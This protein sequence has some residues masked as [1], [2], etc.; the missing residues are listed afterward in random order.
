[1]PTEYVV[2]K[3]AA[4]YRNTRR[5]QKETEDNVHGKNRRKLK[6]AHMRRESKNL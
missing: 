4:I 5:E 3:H 2:C 1:M 6:K